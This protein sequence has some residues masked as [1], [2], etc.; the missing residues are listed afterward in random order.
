MVYA[1]QRVRKHL[2]IGT[3]KKDLKHIASFPLKD[4]VFFRSIFAKAVM[5]LKMKLLE[6]ISSSRTSILL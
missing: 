1:Q 3:K 4:I 6:Y 5:Y 2:N